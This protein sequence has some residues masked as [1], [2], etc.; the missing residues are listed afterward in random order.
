MLSRKKYITN[1]ATMTGQ[2]EYLCWRALVVLGDRNDITPELV[3]QTIAEL[4]ASAIP[5]RQRMRHFRRWL[6]RG[7]Q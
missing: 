3:L 2:S 5:E 1:T 4:P 6:K 7:D